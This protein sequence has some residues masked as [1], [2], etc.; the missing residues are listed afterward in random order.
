MRRAAEGNAEAS[1]IM[2]G[3]LDAVE[4]ERALS[5][6]HLASELGIALGLVNGY[7]KRCIKKGLVK[8]RHT[9]AR[10][11]A[12]FLTPQGFAEKSRLTVE[13]LSYSFGFFR[14]AK[15][16]CLELFRAAKASG[17]KTVLLVGQ[18]E[19]AEI[20]ALCA[21]E[22]AVRIVGVVQAGATSDRFIGLP[23]FADFDAV[24][25][26]FDSVLIADVMRAR[27]TCEDAIARF[28]IERVLVPELLRVRIRQQGGAAE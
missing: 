19:L 14:Q 9:P 16:D 26:P 22:Q 23:V 21:L 8:V 25:E 11:Y 27:A 13:Y 3:L 24:G 4:Q 20:A 7:L 28:G 1:R 17:I 18:S 15:N 6:R 10:R 5:Q 12:Y 2:L